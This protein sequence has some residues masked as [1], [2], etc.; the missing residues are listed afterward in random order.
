[1][2]ALEAAELRHVAGQFATGVVVVTPGTRTA[3]PT[4]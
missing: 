1:M 3:R 2:K 4:G